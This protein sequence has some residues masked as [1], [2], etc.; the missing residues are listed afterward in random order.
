MPFPP[1]V[2]NGFVQIS[3]DKTLALGYVSMAQDSISLRQSNTA[4]SQKKCYPALA[5]ASLDA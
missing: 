4:Y 2:V 1:S 3:A 5:C